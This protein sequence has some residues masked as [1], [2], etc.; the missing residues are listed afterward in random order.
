MIEAFDE[1]LKAY[2]DEYFDIL[3]PRTWNREKNANVVESIKEH[4]DE[5]N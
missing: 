3:D 4:P 2:N 5:T 1:L